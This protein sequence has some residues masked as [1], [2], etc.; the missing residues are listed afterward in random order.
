MGQSFLAVNK[1]KSAVSRQT[2]TAVDAASMKGQNVEHLDT[3]YFGGVTTKLT[4]MLS[5]E[6]QIKYKIV[7]DP[8]KRA[9]SP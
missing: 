6:E 5:L 2:K 9:L 3:N 4:D 7:K 1:K 8:R